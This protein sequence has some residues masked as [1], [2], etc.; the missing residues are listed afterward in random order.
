[1]LENV[2]YKIKD[3]NIISSKDAIKKAYEMEE[4]MLQG[5]IVSEVILEKIQRQIS[6]LLL[7]NQC[8]LVPREN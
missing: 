7:T 3:Y 8:D 2:K 4:N 5:N 1:M 6:S